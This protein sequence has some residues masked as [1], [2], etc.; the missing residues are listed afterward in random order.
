[1]T[2]NLCRILIIAVCFF[3]GF[4]NVFGKIV[5]EQVPVFFL[6]AIRFTL[7]A[8][9]IFTIYRKKILKNLNKQILKN[10]LI[11]GTLTMIC[12]T[13]GTLPLKYI[14][15]SET[16]FLIGICV[17]FAPLTDFI[18]LKKRIQLNSIV[19]TITVT[20]GIYLLCNSAESIGFGIPQIIGLSSS[21]TMALVLSYTSKYLQNTD[22]TVITFM[23]CIVSGVLCGIISIFVEDVNLLQFKFTTSAIM[24]TMYLI[25]FSTIISYIF[26]NIALGKL[27]SVESSLILS[28]ESL[29]SFAGAY[30]ILGEVLCLTQICGAII[31]I[32][33]IVT[34]VLIADTKLFKKVN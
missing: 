18:V 16:S 29:F 7:A 9:I 22:W 1:M 8:I 23:Q 28:A 19:P 17:I 2:K 27:S 15:A 34:A 5:V 4:G 32:A 20:I 33:S 11:I 6:L 10:G 21:L 14:S 3:W 31:I 12:F 25:V 26:Q 24:S 30:L 13:A